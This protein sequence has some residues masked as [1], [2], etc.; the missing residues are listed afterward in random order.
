MKVPWAFEQVFVRQGVLPVC[1]L[2]ILALFEGWIFGNGHAHGIDH[3]FIR[4]IEF[5]VQVTVLPG[6]GRAVA[7]GLD[8]VCSAL[9][10]LFCGKFS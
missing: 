4:E 2:L 7:N 3:P 9:L 8:Q 5:P 6:C 1:D 10:V